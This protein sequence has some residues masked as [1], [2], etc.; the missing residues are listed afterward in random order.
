MITFSHYGSLI[1]ILL[2]I[3]HRSYV[4]IDL[5]FIDM[6]ERPPVKKEKRPK[7]VKG[8]KAVVSKKNYTKY[9]NTSNTTVDTINTTDT[10]NTTITNNINLGGI[11]D[12]LD[13]VLV[14]AKT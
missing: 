8:K 1:P 2:C 13:D 7:K 11:I 3:Y 14:S 10:T 12:K 6:E 9:S 4:D 5:Q